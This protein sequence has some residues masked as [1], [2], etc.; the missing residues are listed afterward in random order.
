MDNR[1]PPDTNVVRLRRNGDPSDEERQR[2]AST[3]FAEQDEIG[4]FSRGNLVPPA[5]TTLAA[6]NQPPAAADPFFEQLQA[7]PTSDETTA[8]A[9]VGERATTAAYFERLGSQTP[10][11]MSQSIEPQPAAAAMLG[12][13]N[14]PGEVTTSRRRRLRRAH[15]VASSPG[16]TFSIRVAAPPLLGA[17][18]ALLVAGAALA[19]VGGGGHRAPA[20][21]RLASPHASAPSSH[22]AAR[23]MPADLEAARS[24]SSLQH[25]STPGQ[26]SRRGRRHRAAKAQVVLAADHQATPAASSSSAAVTPVDQTSSRTIQASPVSQ[27]P[28]S[29]AP[30]A[31]TTSGSGSSTSSGGGSRP[32]WGANGTLGP[33]HSPNG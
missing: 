9:A 22:D 21:K 4:T 24:R 33:G 7:P 8:A 2:L 17:L 27:Q 5:P 6:P 32:P 16:R 10:A 29:P 28:T 23:T 11:E 14:L 3:I 18:G 30:V 20:V 1:K 13:A 31:A 12:S 26:T 19:I 25:H 15:A